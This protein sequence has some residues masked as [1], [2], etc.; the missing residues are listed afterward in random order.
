M[1]S[2]NISYQDRYG[3]V[4]GYQQYGGNYFSIPNKPFW[5]IDGA[6]KWNFRFLQLYMEMSNILN[7]QYIDAGSALQ[8]GRWLRA[9]LVVTFQP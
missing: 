6:V 7:T 2:W 3:E 5:L 9:G 4:M 8:P 1:L